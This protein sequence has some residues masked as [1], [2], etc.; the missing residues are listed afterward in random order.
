[1]PPSLGYEFQPLPACEETEYHQELQEPEAHRNQKANRYHCSLFLFLIFSVA[2]NAISL[3]FWM[4]CHKHGCSLYPQLTKTPVE[5][6]ITYKTVHFGVASDVSIFE[7]EPSPAVDA[8][9]RNLYDFSGS[10]L[11]GY[12]RTPLFSETLEFVKKKGNKVQ[13]LD[14]FHQLHCLDTIRQAFYPQYYTHTIDPSHVVHCINAIRQ[15]L[16]CMADVSD[17]S[18]VWDEELGALV[19]SEANFHTCRD[20]EKI[21]HWALE[22]HYDRQFT[23]AP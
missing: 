22:N 23:G 17:V 13:L 18:W 2:A 10:T 6:E 9:W 20:F 14:V 16:T 4:Q 3:A 12:N 5:G 15:S 8:A 21:K 19:E 7:Q 1:M 11:P